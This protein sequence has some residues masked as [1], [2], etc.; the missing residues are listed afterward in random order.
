MEQHGRILAS[1]QNTPAGVKREN[2]SPISMVTKK[3]E[4][5]RR[6]TCHVQAR[7]QHRPEMKVMDIFH[8]PTFSTESVFDEKPE[9]M[10]EEFYFPPGMKKSKWAVFNRNN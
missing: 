3:E 8:V 6:T 10:N 4:P 5:V 1:V 9:D 7:R 2:K